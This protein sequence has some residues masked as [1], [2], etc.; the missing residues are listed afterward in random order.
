MRDFWELRG[1]KRVLRITRA[2]DL[3]RPVA[4]SLLLNTNTFYWIMTSIDF[5]QE[6]TLACVQ[7]NF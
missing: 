3:V 5:A 7:G 2:L 6:N 4:Y 1:L